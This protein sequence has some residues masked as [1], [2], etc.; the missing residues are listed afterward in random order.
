MRSQIINGTTVYSS[1]LGTTGATTAAGEKLTFMSNTTGSF[2]TSGNVTAMITQPD[3]LL[4]N[5]VIHVV[6]MVLANEQV[7]ESAAS[8]A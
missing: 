3:V 4:E 2:V 5:G 6:D 1:G 7:D 8:S